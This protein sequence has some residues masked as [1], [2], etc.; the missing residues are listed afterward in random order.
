MAIVPINDNS[1]ITFRPRHNFDNQD[2][3]LPSHNIP[4]FEFRPTAMPDRF[5]DI[6]L[7]LDRNF[8]SKRLKLAAS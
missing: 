4:A 2:L 6:W 1:S 5:K 3:I 8:N 7:L